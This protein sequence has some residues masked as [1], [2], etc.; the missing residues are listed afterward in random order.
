MTRFFLWLFHFFSSR[1][2][3][4]YT[5][6]AATVLLFGF[7]AS[8]LQYKENILDLLPRTDKAQK[9][10]V[11]F[12][13]IKV[14][15]KIFIELM[16]EGAS[17]DSLASK[18]DQFVS[19]LERKDGGRYVG[20]ILYRFDTDDIMNLVYYAMDALPCHLGDDFYAAADTLL[21][22]E[23][24]EAISRGEMDAMPTL[25]QSEF[26]IIKNHLFSPDSTLAIAFLSPAFSGLDTKSSSEFEI[27]LSSAVSEFSKSNPGY[28]V[29]YHGET[30]HGCFNSLQIKKDLFLT[31]TISL[32]IICIVLCFCLGGARNLLYLV[33]PILY[34]TLV[35]MAGM[36]WIRG[37]LSI[38]SIGIG[39]L[40]LGV[41]MSYCLHVLV[42]RKFVDDP[43]RL[44]KEQ[45]RPVCLGCLTTV[46]A[47]AGLLLTS[48]ELLFDF[49]IFASLLLIGTTVFALVFLP[50][51]FRPSDRQKNERAFAVIN[52]VNSY[53]LDRN[54]FVVAAIVVLCVVCI[55]F[56]PR[57]GFD[58]DINNLGYK[59]PRVVR[60]ES[61]Y[62]AKVHGGNKLVYYAAH[63]SDLDSAILANRAISRVLDSLKAA[64]DVASYSSADGIMVTTE[65][66]EHNIALWKSY[67]TPSRVK[68]TYGILGRMA[69]EHN[70]AETGFDIPETFLAMTEADF[71]PVSI[72]DAGALP[73][74]LLSNYVEQTPDGGWLV[75]TGVLMPAA[76]ENR[77]STILTEMD[78]IVVL[79]PFFYT[80]DMVQ[81][82]HSDFSK[83]LA[84]SSI[85]VFIVL[86][87]SFRSLIVSLLAFLPMFLSWYVLQ[88][89]M[90]LLGLEFNMLNI[91][92]STFVF[93][94]GVDYSIFVM[95]GLISKNKY[96]SYRLLLCHKTAISFSAFS[97]L[98]V[99]AS[100]LF[101]VHPAISSIGVI[102]LIGMT[103]TILL[104]YALQ[105]LLFRLIMK[106]NF[107]RK[108]ALHEK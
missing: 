32:L 69:E 47:F 24:I 106:N 70:W 1:K 7:Y 12:G 57:V 108:R 18:M 93:G 68:S 43:E 95:D 73:E 4:M 80:G 54:K 31:V 35:A 23:K 66:Q 11:T 79:N 13:D 2:W 75:F 83:V 3:V 42:H 91:M 29:L 94:I 33:S 99:T 39:A 76:N 59:N 41:A 64:G 50:H 30:I 72:V 100:L 21:N 34:G 44:I 46:G 19:I 6:L 81:I 22:E 60:S 63:S 85:F 102:T 74:S 51:F 86:L 87:L 52:K 10:A 97:I 53:P 84:V 37:E 28:E 96:S 104:T 14:K 101:A 98:V 89:A 77:V 15:D 58:D 105:P 88:G 36:Y 90:V 48:S 49:G 107:L 55:I 56:S 5:I 25:P 9:S 38:I 45:A 40:I 82:I 65:E 92:I 16:S 78:K 27:L 61:I 103:S 26:S 8:K 62:N 20:N 17:T 67:W 71:E